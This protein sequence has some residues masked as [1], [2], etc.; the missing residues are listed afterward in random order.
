MRPI[1]I[2]QSVFRLVL[3]G[4]APFIR[5]QKFNGTR[6]VFLTNAE[7]RQWVKDCKRRLDEHLAKFKSPSPRT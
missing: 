2:D 3:D 7:R 1:D 6:W 5:P 4:K